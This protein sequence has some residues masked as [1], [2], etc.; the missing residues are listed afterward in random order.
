MPEMKID[1]A[2]GRA[3]FEKVIETTGTK[4][5][6]FVKGKDWIFKTFNSGWNVI[7]YTDKEAGRIYGEAV[8]QQLTYNNTGVKMNG[9]RFK[10]NFTFLFKDG[11]AKI[12]IENITYKAGEMAGLGSGADISEDYPHTW[13]NFARAYNYKQWK[14]MVPIAIH[15]LQGIILSYEKAIKNT[16]A[17]W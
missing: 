5:E 16:S 17:D 2:T 14:L 15:E 4:D 8:T 6:L 7:E 12:L 11:K 13:T 3:Y 1:S 9:G 10:Y